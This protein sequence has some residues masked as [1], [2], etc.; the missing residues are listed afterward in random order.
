MRLTKRKALELT[1][2]L[3]RY[4]EETG[5]DRKSSWPGWK[6]YDDMEFPCFLCEYDERDGGDIACTHCPLYGKWAG[7]L[8]CDVR[9]APF[10]NWCRAQTKEEGQATSKVIADLCRDE[11]LRLKGR[12]HENTNVV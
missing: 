6:K 4:M 5:S 11:L 8:T 3:W 10:N 1:E 2:E 9:N 7:Y 12:K